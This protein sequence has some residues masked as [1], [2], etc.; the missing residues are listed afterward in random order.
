MLLA[1]VLAGLTAAVDLTTDAVVLA[2]LQDTSG[3]E[4]GSAL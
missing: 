4:H 1:P 3:G 2:G